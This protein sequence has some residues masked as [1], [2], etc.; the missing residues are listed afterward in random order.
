MYLCY[1][2]DI[3]FFIYY[4]YILFNII[5]FKIFQDIRI[6]NNLDENMLLFETVFQ[7]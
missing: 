3:T 6:I 1:Q 4:I 7:T 2:F 5:F